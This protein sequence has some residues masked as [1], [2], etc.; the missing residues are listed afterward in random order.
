M[1]GFKILLVIV[2][3]LL[4]TLSVGK[5][6]LFAQET[7]E[8]EGAMEETL[9][10]AESEASETEEAYEEEGVVEEEPAEVPPSQIVEGMGQGEFAMLLIKELG[11][12]G[13]LPAAATTMDDFALLEKIGCMPPGGWDEES[14]IDRDA[15]CS[16]LGKSECEGSFEELLAK[17]KSRLADIFWNMGIRPMGT[18]TYKTLSPTKT[19]P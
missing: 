6:A 3:S 19:N 7:T 2:L 16:M 12:Q 11:V 9:Q 18:Q 4:L 14:T 1:S 10:G 13:S 5:L 8:E 17:L 15:L